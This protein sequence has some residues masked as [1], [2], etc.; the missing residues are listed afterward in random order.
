[1]YVIEKGV[2]IPKRL[3]AGGR[4]TKYPWD[5]MVVGDSIFCEGKTS[6]TLSASALTW[7]KRH[8]RR[9]ACRNAEGGVRVWRIE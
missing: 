9:F 6:K 2:P 1:M 4:N 5:E 3:Y 7:G 8:G